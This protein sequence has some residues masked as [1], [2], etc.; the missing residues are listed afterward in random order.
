MVLLST[1]D[2]RALATTL[3]ARCHPHY[4]TWKPTAFQREDGAS[5]GLA[6]ATNLHLPFLS[7][8]SRHLV[9]RVKH[10]CHLH[11]LSC[12]QGEVTSR[13][14]VL[15]GFL[16]Q[17]RVPHE[18]RASPLLLQPEGVA[19]ALLQSP[20]GTDPTLQK[21]RP[22]PQYVRRKKAPPLWGPYVPFA[23]F[24]IYPGPVS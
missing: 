16:V 19:E 15:F 1:M 11:D 8:D 13:T 18:A 7:R 20:Q 4:G 12:L 17:Q 21:D 5:L 3:S 22:K 6:G 9:S 2:P 24:P 23:I 10:G 14:A